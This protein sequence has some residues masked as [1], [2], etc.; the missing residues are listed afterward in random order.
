MGYR[1]DIRIEL[2]SPVPTLAEGLVAGLYKKH[3][4]DL[5]ILDFS[6][7]FDIV[8][9][10]FGLLMNKGGGTY[11]WVISF[12]SDRT[13]HVLVEGA[14][15][16]SIPAISGVRQGTTICPLQ[17]MLFRSDLTD[18]VELHELEV[19]SLYPLYSNDI[20]TELQ[21]PLL[22]VISSL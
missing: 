20:K 18:C 19:R 11:N 13:Q 15:S 5:I 4:G 21:A 3:E 2:Q 16:D 22:I 7:T 12:L 14:T 10:Q 6:K 1:S 17:F 9:H 8:P